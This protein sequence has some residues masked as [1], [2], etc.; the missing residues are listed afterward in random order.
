MLTSPVISKG[1]SRAHKRTDPLI[2]GLITALGAAVI[3]I[4][5]LAATIQKRDE[6]ITGLREKVTGMSGSHPIQFY[7]DHGGNLPIVATSR[8]A[9]TESGFT[10][11][12]RNEST[13]DL[14]L[15]LALD[16]RESNRHKAVSI[17]LDPEHTAEFNHFEDWRL[18]AGDAVEISHEGFNSMTMRFR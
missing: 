4:A 7:A 10:L 3:A 18:S 2:A 16:N 11:T 17:V 15:I 5:L 13:E 8:R 12:I 14:S 9:L 1:R 6:T